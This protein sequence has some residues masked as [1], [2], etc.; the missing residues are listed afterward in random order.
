MAKIVSLFD[1]SGVVTNSTLKAFISSLVALNLEKGTFFSGTVNFK[2][3]PAQMGCAEV[4]GV[5][6]SPTLIDLT[7]TSTNVAPYRW[8]CSC[9]TNDSNPQWKPVK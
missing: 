4:H 6:I 1:I 9:W 3:F 8:T 2:D 7:L 5:L